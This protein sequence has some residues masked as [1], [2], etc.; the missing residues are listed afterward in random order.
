MTKV[1]R[2]FICYRQ[3]D[4]GAAAEWLH[5]QLHGRKMNLDIDE[6]GEPHTLDVYLDKSG[7]AVSDWRAVHQPALQLSRALL[8]V[9]SPGACVQHGRHDW[10]HQELNWWLRHRSAAPLLIDPTGEGSRW[11]PHRVRKRWPNAQRIELDAD[12]CQDLDFRKRGEVETRTS[13]RIIRGLTWSDKRIAHDELERNQRRLRQLRLVSL[14][15]VAALC[16]ASWQA[17]VAD[18][19]LNDLRPFS[20]MQKLSDYRRVA[21][22]S[23]WPATPET[24]PRMEEWVAAAEE[25]IESIPIHAAELRELRS[26]FPERSAVSRLDMSGDWWRYELLEA[27]VPSLKKFATGKE[28]GSLQDIRERLQFAR[29]VRSRSLIDHADRWRAASLAI[30]RSPK[31]S[32][33]TIRP[34]LGLVP[35]R[36]DPASGLWEFA[37][38][39]TG[40]SSYHG[41]STPSTDH[42]G[43]IFVLLPGGSFFMGSQGDDQN[44][45]NFDE[46]AELKEGPVH[47]V[48]LEPF[49]MSKYEMTQAQWLRVTKT[50]PSLYQPGHENEEG[51]FSLRHPVEKVG[52]DDCVR[53]LERMELSLPTEAQWEYAARGGTST[54]WW[55]GK[56]RDSLDGA[57][58]LAD[59]TAD[60]AGKTW[61]P[62]QE[63]PEFDDGFAVHAPVGSFRPNKFGLH[64]T[65]GNVWEWCLDIEDDYSLPCRRGDGL[66]QSQQSSKKRV[67]RGSC[68]T[69]GV[70]QARSAH[71]TS[72][73]RDYRTLTTGLRPARAIR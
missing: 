22:D 15:L 2:V 16:F 18:S 9:C 42:D 29:S 43:L 68:Y 47:A 13:S 49:F 28:L 45:L 36:E 34:Q 11:V 24:A 73:E 17:I 25:L 12:D 14:L 62:I 37:H 5:S 51:E 30:E 3:T 41:R 65:C 40:S 71:R 60:Q 69:Y 39:E 38:L 4:G 32:G 56:D 6:D 63:W 1:F 48:S 54:P 66:R 57:T 35:I 20:D 44:G 10:V 53:V 46:R 21:L 8:L 23:L 64:D 50:N 61:A 27:L 31:Y 70:Q 7:P 72:A 26:R 33:L 19:R 58:N 59:K 55:T 67:R 52:W